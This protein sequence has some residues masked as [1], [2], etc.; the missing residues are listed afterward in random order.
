[1]ITGAVTPRDYRVAAW[2]AAQSQ[3]RLPARRR[4]RIGRAD[5]QLIN[6]KCPGTSCST[7]WRR[8]PIV[9]TSSDPLVAMNVAAG[10]VAATSATGCSGEYDDAAIPIWAIR[11]AAAPR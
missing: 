2:R 11:H 4:F 1:V 7:G 6:L 5:L 8:P 3:I 10:S 9:T